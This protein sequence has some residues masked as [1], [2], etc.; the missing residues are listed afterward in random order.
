[1]PGIVVHGRPGT[2]TSSKPKL[3]CVV[4]TNSSPDAVLRGSSRHS[5][6][7]EAYGDR[8]GVF[9]RIPQGLLGGRPR[10]PYRPHEWVQNVN[11]TAS[12][13]AALHCSTTSFLY[14]S[15]LGQAS[16]KRALCF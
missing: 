12:G 14:S 11:T 7:R 6:G 1:M 8:A 4:R 10:H 13:N 9:E 15:S 3:N 16:R 2:S 5:S